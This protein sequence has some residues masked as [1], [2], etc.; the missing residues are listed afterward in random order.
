MVKNL[1]IVLVLFIFCVNFSFAQGFNYEYTPVNVVPEEITAYWNTTKVPLLLKKTAFLDWIDW[2]INDSPVKNQLYCGGCWAFAAVALVENLGVQTD[3]S[4]QVII[5]CATGD[6]NGGWYGNALGYIH[7]IGIPPES[8]YPYMALDGNC[9]DECPNPEYLERILS[10]TFYGLWGRPTSGTIA[11]LKNL[12]QSAPVLVSMRV[13]EGNTFTGYSGGVYNYKGKTIPPNRGHAVLVVG[14][15]DPSRYFKVKNSWGEDWG[16]EGYFRI[17]YEDV[18]GNVQFGG[19]ACTASGAYT[20][21]AVYS[22]KGK[23]LT[24]DST[25]VGSVEIVLWSPDSAWTA[26]TDSTGLF[27]ANLPGGDEYILT[28]S[29]MKASGRWSVHDVYTVLM[30]IIG[31]NPLDSLQLLLADVSGDSTVDLLD[32]SLVF[33]RWAGIISSFPAGEDWV[34]SPSSMDFNPLKS[35]TTVFFTGFIRGD[36]FTPVKKV[37]CLA[38]G[39]RHGAGSIEI[40]F[41]PSR[42]N[43]LILLDGD[44]V[45]FDNLSAKNINFETQLSKDYFLSQNYPNPFN[46]TTIINYSIPES[47]VVKIDVYNMVGQKVKTLVDRREKPGAYSIQFDASDMASGVYFYKIKASDYT[48]TKKMMLVR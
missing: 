46:P 32:C 3:L 35:D 31:I 29:K 24:Q 44:E 30:H 16:E 1:L 14:Y 27:L 28:P 9:A 13:P 39:K 38:I 17:S 26:I 25:G 40:V 7:D 42:D 36:V 19:F 20:V 5:S 34:F 12:L 11:D 23:I 37:S 33:Q 18:T 2:S 8:C 41:N 45:S 6:C 22:I 48:E 15:N 43:F 10:Y 47:G 4:E 21:P